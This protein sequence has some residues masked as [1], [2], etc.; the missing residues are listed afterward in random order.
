MPF[1][2]ILEL[3][4][5]RIFRYLFINGKPRVSKEAFNRRTEKQTLTGKACLFRRG[6][7]DHQ[8]QKHWRVRR[9]SLLVVRPI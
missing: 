9:L 8:E 3:L 7:Q 4:L 6:D 2:I 5:F 1:F